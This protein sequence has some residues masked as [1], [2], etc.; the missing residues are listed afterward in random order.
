MS[1]QKV[2]QRAPKT[3]RAQPRRPSPHSN[4]TI[5]TILAGLNFDCDIS[6]TFWPNP[7]RTFTHSCVPFGTI[8]SSSKNA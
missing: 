7:D 1:G 6:R 3:L 2:T 8:W 4:W 5:L